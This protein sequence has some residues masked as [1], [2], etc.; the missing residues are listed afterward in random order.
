MKTS[1]PPRKM[2]ARK[3]SH[4]GSYSAADPPSGND[5]ASLASIGSIGG[6]RGKA[7]TSASSFFRTVAGRHA[8][9]AN[10]E[11][12]ERPFLIRGRP[13]LRSDGG[14]S[15]IDRPGLAGDVRR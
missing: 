15:W 4:L 13:A 11:L 5:S 10:P 2:M 9:A 14:P 3:P 1:P 6:S 12:D 8:H 7:L